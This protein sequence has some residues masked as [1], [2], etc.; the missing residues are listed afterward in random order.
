M[1]ESVKEK[2]PGRPTKL[3]SICERQASLWLVWDSPSN[4]SEG[5]VQSYIIERRE[6]L[7]TDGQ[8]SPWEV[9][10][11]TCNHEISLTHQPQRVFLEYRIKAINSI[12]EGLPCNTISVVL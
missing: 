1:D 12:G 8:F 2:I 11:T 5:A 4:D 9:I 6:K 7:P 10:D 3:H